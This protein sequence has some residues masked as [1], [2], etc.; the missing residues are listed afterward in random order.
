MYYYI[1]FT[2][3]GIIIIWTIGSYLVVKNIEEPK[4]VVLEKKKGYE[5]RKYSSYITAQT[6]ISSNYTE[7]NTQG[8]RLI[9][10][11]IFGNNTTKISIAM[12]APVLQNKSEKISM[13]TPVLNTLK[14]TNKRI[15]SF[16]LPSKYT[17]ETLPTPNN[18]KVTLIEVP[19]RIVAV[20]RFNW[21]ATENKSAAMQS[22]L[23]K[24]VIADGFTIL[25]PAQVAQYNPPFSMPLMRRNEIIIPVENNTPSI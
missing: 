15:I 12:T 3:L 4:Y 20:V 7:A 24:Q 17:M 16:V 23:E 21:Y 19:S 11:Y 1:L 10:D 14:D 25:G 13:T 22:L 8:F 5:L 6:E 2:F 9:A 18:Q